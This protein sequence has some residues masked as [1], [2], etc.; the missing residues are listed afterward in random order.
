MSRLVQTLF[1]SLSILILS[2]CQTTQTRVVDRV[3]LVTPP[4]Q[5]MGPCSMT[6]PPE[7][8]TYLDLD[9]SEKEAMLFHYQS[10][11]LEDLMLCNVKWVQ[12]RQ[13]KDDQEKLY[14]PPI[15]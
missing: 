6:P 10:R 2:G 1:V 13:W 15:P 7:I 4:N 3:V 8:Q 14:H 12:L 11:L 5:L 9:W